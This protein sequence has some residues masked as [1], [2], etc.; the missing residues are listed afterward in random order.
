MTLLLRTFIIATL[1]LT[2]GSCNSDSGAPKASNI[3]VDFSWEKQHRCSSV[4]PEIHLSGTPQTTK[5]LKV[6]LTDRDMPSY[7]H[8]GGVVKYVGSNVIP[9]GALEGYSGP[10]PPPS[11]QHNYIIKVQA[12]DASGKIVG[13]GEKAVPCCQ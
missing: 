12:I 5:E 13:Q 7:D 6:S 10:C 8:G 4:F 3:Q 2:L 1:S 9:E 11:A